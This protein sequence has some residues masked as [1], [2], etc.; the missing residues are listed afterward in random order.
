MKYMDGIRVSA[1]GVAS[2]F[3]RRLEIVGRAGE[4]SMIICLIFPFPAHPAGMITGLL[5]GKQWLQFA[6]EVSFAAPY[7]YIA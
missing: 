4:A 3:S 2:A 7:I 1:K 5:K 6:K